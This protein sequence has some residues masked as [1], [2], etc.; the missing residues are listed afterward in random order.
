[1]SSLISVIFNFRRWVILGFGKQFT[2]VFFSLQVTELTQFL[3][4]HSEILGENIPNLLD[5]D[6]GTFTHRSDLYNYL[7]V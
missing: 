6:E 5:T 1:M 2:Y 3:I 7:P 4:E